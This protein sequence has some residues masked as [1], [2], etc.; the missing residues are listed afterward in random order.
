MQVI[1]RNPD[2]DSTAGKQP[3][4]PAAKPRQRKKPA[5]KQAAPGQ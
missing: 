3:P 2:V 1:G 5:A 4:E